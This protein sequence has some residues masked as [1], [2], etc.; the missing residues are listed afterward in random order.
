ME[1]FVAR[2]PWVLCF[3]KLFVS[4]KPT[5]CVGNQ[6]RKENHSLRLSCTHRTAQDLKLLKNRAERAQ[7]VGMSHNRTGRLHRNDPCPRGAAQ[8]NFIRLKS[9]VTCVAAWSVPQSR[10]GLQHKDSIAA[11]G[12]CTASSATR[13]ILVTS[14]FNIIPILARATAVRGLSQALSPHHCVFVS[15]CSPS[16]DRGQKKNFFWCSLSFTLTRY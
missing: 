15:V 7:V 13:A 8:C 2:S 3:D 16:K 5:G 1:Q 6:C 14:R 10:G 11:R 9:G 12:V 4:E